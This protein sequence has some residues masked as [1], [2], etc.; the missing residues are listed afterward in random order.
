MRVTEFQALVGSLEHNI[1][2]LRDGVAYFSN[3]RELLLRDKDYLIGERDTLNGAINDLTSSVS[4]KLTK[5]LRALWRLLA[6][7]RRAG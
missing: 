1:V 5:P 4:W 2:E 3:E 7:V 6:F